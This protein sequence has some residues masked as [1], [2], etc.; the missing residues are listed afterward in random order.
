MA[1]PVRP[2][3]PLSGRQIASGIFGI[4]GR[5][6][7]RRWAWVTLVLVLVIWIGAKACT[8]Y[9][10][11]NMM[12]IKQVYLGSSKGIGKQIYGPGLHL[13]KPGFERYHL[14]PRDIQVVS[15][16]DS[17][18]ESSKRWRT[19]PA[20]KVQTSDGYNVIL[21]VTVLYRIQDPYKVFVEAG[22]GRAFEA[23]LVVPRVDRIMRK[24][25]GE[26]NS[27]EFYRGPRRI[28]KANHARTELA[29]ELAPYGIE[30]ND[31][32]VRNYTYD[33][34]YQALIEGRKLKDQTVFLRK[35]E[36]AAAI[37]ER[38]RD[39]FVAQGSAAVNTELARGQAEVA[40][41][42]AQ[43]DLYTR[44]KRAEGQLLID[45]AEAEGTRKENDALQLAGSENMVG[46]R[47]A[48]V[49]KG[50]KIL[51]LPSDG[52]SGMNPLNLAGVLRMFE[53]P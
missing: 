49:L 45:T 34:K 47:M 12:A 1:S 9:V 18:S 28:E 13:V 27:E 6:F 5:L 51:V 38:K 35:A 26:L 11:P 3:M 19:A 52:A 31:V 36:A 39:T 32:L 14:F 42:T 46:L 10:P 22:S 44:Q 20:I 41:L 33:E 40:K 8:T 24:T 7:K 25:L 30:L 15:F 23:K 43:A 16:T 48:D 29:A 37:E 17:Q 50:V 2:S 21:D 4:L 53:V